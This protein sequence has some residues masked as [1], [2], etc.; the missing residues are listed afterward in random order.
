MSRV[1]SQSLIS[2]VNSLCCLQQKDPAFAQNNQGNDDLDGPDDGKDGQPI[3][4]PDSTCENKVLGDDTPATKGE[5]NDVSGCKQQPSISRKDSVG[6]MLLNLPR[7]ASLPQFL[8]HIS[9]D[10]ENQA[11]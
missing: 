10:G 3:S 9:E 8:F 1:N 11:R 7:I 2:R 5:S 6:D 4:V